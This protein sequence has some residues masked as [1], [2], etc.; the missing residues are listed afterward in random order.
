MIAR[1]EVNAFAPIVRSLKQSSFGTSFPFVSLRRLCCAASSSVFSTFCT[2]WKHNQSLDLQ[3]IL[4]VA[5]HHLNDVFSF[6][7]STILAD[8]TSFS[9]VS[10]K[11]AGINVSFPQLIQVYFCKKDSCKQDSLPLTTHHKIRKTK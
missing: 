7:P 11:Y 5:V 1:L 8:F 10:C 9:L 3:Q 4:F 2:S 6:P